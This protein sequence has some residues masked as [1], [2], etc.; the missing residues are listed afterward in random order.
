MNN[1]SSPPKIRGWVYIITNKAMPGLIKVGYSTKD[2][3]LRARELGGTGVPHPFIVEADFL[4]FS[5]RAVEKK[6]HA[7]LEEFREG[8]EW[9]RCAASVA[10]NA[11]NRYVPNDNAN[12]DELRE[13]KT[14]FKTP[15][16]KEE[17]LSV[18][19]RIVN[20]REE[21]AKKYYENIEKYVWC[22]YCRTKLSKISK[23]NA[24]YKCSKCNRSFD[25]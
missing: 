24:I 21:N 10:I 8:K 15:A 16:E 4:C 20:Q 12:M 22:P 6:V 1:D 11:I 9:F 18:V 5:P 3:Q 2:P 13:K 19:R 17:F 25:Q 14:R 23:A 7:E